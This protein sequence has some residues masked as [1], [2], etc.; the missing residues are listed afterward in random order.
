MAKESAKSKKEKEIILKLEKL[1][2][3]TKPNN[4][5]VSNKKDN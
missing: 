2:N 4:N 3:D 1:L 5:K